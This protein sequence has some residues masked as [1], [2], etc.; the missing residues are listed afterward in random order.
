MPST[1]DLAI[2]LPD[3]TKIMEPHK[4]WRRNA[5]RWR[6]LVDSWEA[7]E[8]YRLAEYGKDRRGWPIHNLIRHK[9]E[10]PDPY[11]T[12]YTPY[13]S[14]RP[15]TDQYAAA[16]DSDDYQLRLARTPVPTHL[17]DAIEEILGKIYEREVTR[18]TTS[19]LLANWWKNV[20]GRGTDIDRWMQDTFAPLL[21]SLA[22]LDAA[23]DHPQPPEGV[24]IISRDDELRYKLGACLASI[25]LPTE[26]V[27][28]ELDAAGDYSRILVRETRCKIDK[29]GS[30]DE[31]DVYRYWDGS[32]WI[33]YEAKGKEIDRRDH[34]FGRVPIVRVFDQRRPRSA[35]VGKPRFESIAERQR[36]VYNLDSERILSNTLQAHPITQGPEDYASG[37]KQVPLGPDYMLPM[38]KVEGMGGQTFYQEWKVL[39]FPKGAAEELRTCMHDQEEAIDRTAHLTKP[40]GA[41]GATGRVVGQSGISKRL[42]HQT[43]NAFLAKLSR[44]LKNAERKIAEFALSVLTEDRLTPAQ[45]A[46]EVNAITIGYPTQFDLFD[47]SELSKAITEFQSIA[48]SAGAMPEIEGEMLASLVRTILPGRDDDQYTLYDK[49][50]ERYLAARAR[51]IAQSRE[52]SLAAPSAGE[53][54]GRGSSGG[55]A[56]SGPAQPIVEPSDTAGDLDE[57]ASD[58]AP[59][60]S[61]KSA[62]GTAA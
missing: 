44:V 55:P 37:D 9:R 7:G 30:H 41:T 54:S 46:A 49:E 24:Q 22:N 29:R 42:D 11:E 8:V 62:D 53:G 5:I 3:G 48:A 36:E 58:N 39:D 43:G 18:T 28:W 34:R 21:L 33:L 27:W 6:W 31:E 35:N 57:P 16:A 45:F 13:E 4:E 61:G 17:A 23:F 50:I 56:W 1:L 60:E 47:A 25:V 38:K 32:Q 2:T 10:Y 20:D 52:G 40:A 19:P 59:V 12:G 14:R 26:V 15:G 51:D